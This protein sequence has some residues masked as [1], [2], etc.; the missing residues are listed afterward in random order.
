MGWCSSPLCIQSSGQAEAPEGR[1]SPVRTSCPI[2]L[3][4]LAV[5]ADL[6]VP[7]GYVLVL[8]GSLWMRRLFGGGGG[9]GADD[10]QPGSATREIRL[11]GPGCSKYLPGHPGNTQ[12][13]R[14]DES[15]TSRE[16]AGARARQSPALGSHL[17][18]RARLTTALSQRN[19]GRWS[20]L[21]MPTLFFRETSCNGSGTCSRQR[22]TGG[23]AILELE[24]RTRNP[25][26]ARVN[27]MRSSLVFAGARW[28]RQLGT[29][30][31]S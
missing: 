7:R 12:S 14:G 16:P 11:T 30:R 20:D 19:T 24:S 9:G 5:A 29:A 10:L 4:E 3:W 17:S 15:R 8:R 28:G 13:T 2:V 27:R 23:R 21:A 18:P 1:A 26:S 25:R 22:E 31:E 6:V